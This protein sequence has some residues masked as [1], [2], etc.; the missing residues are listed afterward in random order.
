M[1][2][3]PDDHP[4]ASF[5]AICRAAPLLALTLCVQISHAQSTA[6]LAKGGS[7]ELSAADVQ[8]LVAALPEDA[9]KSVHSNLPALEQVLR[10]EIAQRAILA[11]AR[12]KGFQHDANAVKQLARVQDE[13]LMR[14]WLASKATVPA[15]YPTDVQI[16]ATYDAAKSALPLEYHIAQIFISVP[17]GSDASKVAAALKKATDLSARL[18]TADFAQLA[19][20]QSDHA[21]SAKNGGDLGFI[22]VDRMLPDIA[23]S[24]QSL[25]NGQ[26][27]GPLKTSEGLHFVKLIESRPIAL[28]PLA[29]VRDRLVADL[30]ARKAQELERAYIAELTGKLGISINEIELAKLQPTLN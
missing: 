14:L 15:D 10:A 24:V 4:C 2:N 28:P 12:A 7:I 1:R 9:R 8:M 29:N 23:K 13:A 19:R 20:E 3:T 17:N 22:A 30:R 18:A 11:D 6:V 26:V 25:S 27:T 21:D 5:A 16:K